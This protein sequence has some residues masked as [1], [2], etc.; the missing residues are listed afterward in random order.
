M[1]A[2][3]WNI[4]PSLNERKLELLSKALIKEKP[5]ILCVAEGSP[6]TDD[7]KLLVE[8]LEKMGCHCYY[9]LLFS[10]REELAFD[11]K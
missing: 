5:D 9:L 2:L 4:G 7:C 10:K 3:F 6:G 11:V 1:K 8:H